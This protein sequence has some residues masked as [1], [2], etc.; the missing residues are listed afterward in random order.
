MI[1]AKERKLQRLES[2]LPDV[3]STNIYNLL[4]G[5]C[6]LYGI[7][8]NALIVHCF[9]DYFS[10]IDPIA[11]LIGYFACCFLGIYITRSENPIASFIGYNLV[12]LPIGALLS[13]CLPQYASEDIQLAIVITAAVV[14]VMTALATAFPQLFASMGNALLSAFAVS[15]VAELVAFF[16][17]NVP[18]IFNWLFVIIFSLYIAYDWQKAQEYPKTLDNAIDSALDIY[19]D[20]INLFVRILKIIGKSKRKK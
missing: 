20:V 10:T 5:S 15:F 2:G 14:G 19:L 11:F 1:D 4:I 17:G 12:V 13:V 9:S 8:L 16:T 18:S 3:L 7:V 6:V